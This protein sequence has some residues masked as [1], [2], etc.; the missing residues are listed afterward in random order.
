MNKSWRCCCCRWTV[1]KS[2]LKHP[3]VWGA[4]NCILI[5]QFSDILLPG[6]SH[7]SFK[8]FTFVRWKTQGTQIILGLRMTSAV[9]DSVWGATSSCTQK[10]CFPME[11][12]LYVTV[13]LCDLTFHPCDWL[14]CSE[15]SVSLMTVYWEFRWRWWKVCRHCRRQPGTAAMPLGPGQRELPVF[16]YPCESSDSGDMTKWR[17]SSLGVIWTHLWLLVKQAKLENFQRISIKHILKN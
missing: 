12:L 9:W 8:M 4:K 14:G 10:W 5:K 15:A 17:S 7:I 3:N 13:T 2:P 1:Y 16:S 6:V 11:Q